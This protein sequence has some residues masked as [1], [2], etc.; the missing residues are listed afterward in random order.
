VIANS[1]II[2]ENTGRWIK[3][4]LRIHASVA[5]GS[6]LEKVKEILLEAATCDERISKNPSPWVK[7][8]RFGENA[9]EFE[10]RCWIRDPELRGRVQDA[11]NSRVY[12]GL[13]EQGFEIPFPKRD[14]YLKEIPE[15]L[16]LGISGKKSD[17]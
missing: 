6:D 13:R 16:K 2:N 3:Q 15:E 10:I 4:R 11:V 5:Y 12:N 8:H 17:S 9:L 14:L 1:K 7:F